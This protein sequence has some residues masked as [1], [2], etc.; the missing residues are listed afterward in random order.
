MQDNWLCHNSLILQY[1]CNLEWPL[2]INLQLEKR[3]KMFYYLQTMAKRI[4]L[5]S[6]KS[7]WSSK[8]IEDKNLLKVSL[9]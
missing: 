8:A 5:S 6:A 2:C 4:K 1:I 3:K 9:Y 7:S